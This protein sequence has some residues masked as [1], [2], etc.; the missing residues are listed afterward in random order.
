M[1]LSELQDKRRSPRTR[2]RQRAKVE[3]AVAEILQELGTAK[4]F[5][6]TIEEREVET[7]RQEGRGRPTE[8]TRYVRQAKTFFELKHRVEFERLLAEVNS[9]GFFPLITNESSVSERGLLLA[10]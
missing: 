5:T 3:E 9:D 6:I 7:F 2:Y 10:Q 4:W 8:R 1:R